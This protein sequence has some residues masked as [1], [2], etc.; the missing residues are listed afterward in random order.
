MDSI[1]QKGLTAK[2]E[3]KYVEFKEEFDPTSAEAMCELIKDMVAVAN[4]GGGVIIIG[5][6]SNGTA[7]GSD[8]SGVLGLDPAV[9]TDRVHKY[10][11]YQFN[12]FEIIDCEK[13]GVKLVS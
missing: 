12:E 7:T 4:S 11:G 3:S 10:T 1:L 2:R 5:L 8:V 9:V 13:D 6:R